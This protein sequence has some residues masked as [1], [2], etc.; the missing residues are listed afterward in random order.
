[1][2]LNSNMAVFWVVAPCI[3]Y[4]F[5]DVSEVLAVYVISEMIHRCEDRGRKHL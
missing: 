5:A 2:N 4:K 3:F 1:M